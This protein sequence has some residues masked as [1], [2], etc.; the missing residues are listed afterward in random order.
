[1]TLKKKL[2]LKFEKVENLEKFTPLVFNHKLYF[3]ETDL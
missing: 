2:S 3:F 1:M